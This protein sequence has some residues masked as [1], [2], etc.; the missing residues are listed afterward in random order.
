MSL[1]H[2]RKPCQLPSESRSVRRKIQEK[3]MHLSLVWTSQLFPQSCM[4]AAV[5]LGPWQFCT[6]HLLGF[7]PVPTV[8]GRHVPHLTMSK[9]AIGAEARSSIC[10]PTTLPSSVLCQDHC[11]QHLFTSLECSPALQLLSSWSPDSCHSNNAC[12]PPQT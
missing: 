10:L 11:R 8:L 12:Q 7:P 9:M 6:C 5:F 2:F 3:K 1:L 4:N